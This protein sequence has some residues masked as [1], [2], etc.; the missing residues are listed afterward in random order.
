MKSPMNMAPNKMVSPAKKDIKNPS[1]KQK[2]AF[3]VNKDGNVTGAE[4]SSVF[5][6]NSPAKMGSA[7]KLDKSG[8]KMKS[9]PVNMR[10][11]GSV[12]KMAG[13]SPMKELVDVTNEPKYS[14]SKKE[15]KTVYRDSNTGQITTSEAVEKKTAATKMSSPAKGGMK[16]FTMAERPGL[17]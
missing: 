12:A 13:V 16:H 14:K 11:P 15:G 6:M 3:D 4:M 5:N 9:A 17:I 8:F 1:A 10:T 7:Y 2:A